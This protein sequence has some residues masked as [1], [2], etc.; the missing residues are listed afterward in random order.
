MGLD[1]DAES[2]VVGPPLVDVG[3]RHRGP[4]TLGI[5]RHVDGV[6]GV[7]VDPDLRK[8]S[9]VEGRRRDLRDTPAAVTHQAAGIDDGSLPVALGG[10]PFS[11]G[12]FVPA[13]R[14]RSGVG[15]RQSWRQHHGDLLGNQDEGHRGRQGP[16]RNVAQPKI[17]VDAHSGCVPQLPTPGFDVTVT[18]IF[19][20]SGAQVK[21]VS[22]NTR[23]IPEDN[24]KCTPPVL[25]PA[26]QP[27]R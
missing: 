6:R 13:T 26:V 17:I 5:A 10:R 24:V 1:E 21:T 11:Q 16:R 3:P 22:F 19:K 23:Y 14:A 7:L 15:R 27:P 2:R 18:Q 4:A 20:K 25:P 12:G 8:E 9:G